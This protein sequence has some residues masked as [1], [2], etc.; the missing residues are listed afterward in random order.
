M[1]TPQTIY[2]P[3]KEKKHLALTE[4]QKD[5]VRG[6]T[7]G[8]EEVDETIRAIALVDVIKTLENG[9]PLNRLITDK[10]GEIEGY[11]AC[12]DFV[13]HEAYIKYLG[14]TK[15]TGRNLLQEIPAFLEYAKELGYSKL[16]FHGWNERLNHIL[17]RYGFERIR[18]DKMEDLAID[19][20]E[21]SLG[22]QK[23]EESINEERKRA[24]EQKYI[25]ELNQKYQQTLA[26]FS[27]EN[28]RE[29]ERTINDTFQTLRTRL[30]AQDGLDF[31]ER[32]KLV[33]KLKLARH[34]QTNDNCD[35]STLFDA[36]IE[37]P[38]F[39]NTDKGS[40]RRLLELHGEKTLLK[41]AE[42]RKRR[43][44]MSGTE[45]FNP[46]ENLYTTKSGDYYM[47]RLLNMPHLEEESEYMKNCVGT[48][49]SY[50]NKMKRGDIEILS[51]R[52]TPKINH[53]T[54]KLEGD[55]PVMTIEYN[56]KT[57]VIEQMKKYDDKFLQLNDPYFKDVIDTL[58]Q[59]R[60]TRTD[61]GELR[62]FSRISPSE[63]E[64]IKVAD[65]SVLTEYGE[66]SLKDFNPDENTF[67]LKTGTMDTTH[68]MP[69][70]DVAK[71]LRIFG[72][73]EVDPNHIVT[74]FTDITK[75]TQVFCSVQGDNITLLDYR[76]E[77]NK[78]KLQAHIEFVKKKKEHNSTLELEFALEGG[79]FTV[80]LD[81]TLTK[82]T[83]EE[84]YLKGT[85]SPVV[86][87][88]VEQFT[89]I[90]PEKSSQEFFM[91]TVDSSEWRSADKIVE[92]M[93]RLGL[94]PPTYA[95]FIQMLTNNPNLQK[96]NSLI[97]LDIQIDSYGDARVP[98]TYWNDGR[99]ELCDGLWSDG[100]DADCR[101]PAVRR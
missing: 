49:D 63:L 58:K 8:I 68:E 20:Y 51:F 84:A 77:K 32:Q 22:E 21:K 89:Y 60:T 69:K 82:E 98:Y 30:T 75:T 85:D 56:L 15:Q 71:I 96:I 26:T 80:S 7:L 93:D 48:S 19:F 53:Q 55:T 9:H 1:E 11:I 86:Y 43:A 94:R 46:Y 73:A 74:S 91:F 97:C 2:A 34:F 33:L 59:L 79:V 47:A 100:W 29:K 78:D 76:E 3:E 18:T 31:S 28:R 38:K 72:G 44:E 42:I 13:P 40:L 41:I 61:T 35:T 83:A 37:S 62:N 65:Y 45:G 27:E 90:T 88:S 101:F 24:F 54:Q 25:T 70:E 67:I 36:I 12:E 92:E 95:E 17:T 5:A 81:K 23:S 10:E 66:V 87:V 16:N 50:I 99:R 14:T 39:I 64:N 52:R 6:I 57:K 4:Q